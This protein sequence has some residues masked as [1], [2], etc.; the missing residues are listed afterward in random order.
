MNVP[1]FLHGSLANHRRGQVLKEAISAQAIKSLPDSSSIIL[2]FGEAFQVAEQDE[3]AQLIEWTRAPGHVLLLLPPF[4]KESCHSP[5]TWQATRVSKAPHGGEGLS[6]MLAPEVGY[7]LSGKLQV[8]VIPGATWSDLS[9]GLGVYRLHPAAGL[10]AVTCLPLWSLTVL[11]SPLEL[12]H[13]LGRLV[14]L[15]GESKPAQAPEPTPLLA[16]HYGFLVFL[17]SWPLGDEEQAIEGLRSSPVFQISP[18]RGLSLL[19]DLQVRGLVDGAKPTT[20]AEELVMQSP[21]AHYVSALR[22]VNRS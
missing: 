8:P 18:K 17:L 1:I 11:D 9:V 2:E 21:Y 4:T 16:D 13:W 20:E 7:Q 22:E 10:F 14:L 19:K 6:Q 12:E 5:V 15:A 3:C